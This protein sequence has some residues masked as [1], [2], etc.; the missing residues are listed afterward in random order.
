MWKAFD[1]YMHESCLFCLWFD[2][3]FNYEL[4]AGNELLKSYFENEEKQDILRHITYPHLFYAGYSVITLE[5][6]K[7]TF[8]VHSKKPWILYCAVL[9]PS[10]NN[11]VD[12]ERP[13]VSKELCSLSVSLAGLTGRSFFFHHLCT[14]YKLHISCLQFSS[15]IP[16]ANLKESIV[17]YL[18]IYCIQLMLLQLA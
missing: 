6:Q 15:S 14:S 13:D 2:C 9:T 17:Q 5:S 16:C 7:G 11:A 12:G 8:S 4:N 18:Y 10:S 3:F 1:K